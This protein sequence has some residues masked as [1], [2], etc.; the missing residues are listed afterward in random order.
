MPFVE[1]TVWSTETLAPFSHYAIG[2]DVVFLE[3]DKGTSKKIRDALLENNIRSLTEPSKEQLSDV[4]S[5]LEEP[6]VVFRRKETYATRMDNRV[7]LAT[8]ERMLVDLYFYI[9]RLEFPY[10]PDE[11][12]RLVYN[13]FKTRTLN[14]DML[15]KYASR[16]GVRGEMDLL[17][18]K[19]RDR[20]PDLEIPELEE[21]VQ[22]IE[23]ILEEMVGGAS[24]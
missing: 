16:R 20:Y 22:G 5:L 19:M 4:F 6:V 21:K 24:L 17:L 8:L 9:T 7:R 18:S 13:V 1:F 23:A 14:V 12:G 11:Y 10:P 2:R 15:R 3:A